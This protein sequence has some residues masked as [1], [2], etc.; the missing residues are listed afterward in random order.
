MYGTKD[1]VS[2]NDRSKGHGDHCSNTNSTKDSTKKPWEKYGKFSHTSD[3][4]TMHL[5]Q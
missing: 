5:Y 1:C 3:V 4:I 2:F